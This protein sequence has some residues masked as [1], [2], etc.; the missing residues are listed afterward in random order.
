MYEQNYQER[1]EKKF[2]TGERRKSCSFAM[3]LNQFYVARRWRAKICCELSIQKYFAT[4]RK[5]WFTH[6]IFE[7]CGAF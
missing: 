7:Y 1:K 5:L 2:P 3:F 6:I 4:A